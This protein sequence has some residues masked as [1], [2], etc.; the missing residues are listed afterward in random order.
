MD[1]EQVPQQHASDEFDVD[2][3]KSN[4]GPLRAA[5]RWAAGLVDA[6]FGGDGSEAVGVAVVVHRIDDHS[7]VIR[8]NAGSIEEAE[9]LVAMV[10]S[11]LAELSHEDF[12]DRWS[13]ADDAENVS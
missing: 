6:F 5:T 2:L 3:E 4:D 8:I 10:R 12:L 9:S 11:D 1:N 7:E 13:A